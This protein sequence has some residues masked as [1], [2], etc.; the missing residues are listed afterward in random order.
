MHK[1]IKDD[2]ER[3]AKDI[4]EG[5]TTTKTLKQKA[6]LVYEQ[7]T[8]LKFVEDKIKEDIL[9]EE[10]QEVIEQQLGQSTMP[11]EKTLEEE[12]QA[13]ISNQ[14]A[15]DLFVRVSEEKESV[16]ENLF[17]VNSD[18]EVQDKIDL[19]THLFNGSQ[20]DFNR[21]FSQLNSFTSEIE[22][23][24]FILNFVKPDYN[25][26]GKAFYEQKLFSFIAKKFL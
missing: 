18:I 6:L 23:K 14:D 12:L 21:V 13:A 5:I 10:K 20:E 8:L 3:L 11:L 9:D 26:S 19:V 16:K 4:L 22:A 24:D 17:S 25:W 2:L 15:A 7:L 1:K